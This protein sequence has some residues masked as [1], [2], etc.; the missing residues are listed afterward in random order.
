LNRVEDT[1]FAP[2]YRQIDDVKN[3]LTEREALIARL[4]TER[5]GFDHAAVQ[6]GLLVVGSGVGV[7]L[8]L[9][10]ILIIVFH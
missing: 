6:K 7:L 3:A 8:V 5:H 10:L 4:E 9:A 1:R 2:L